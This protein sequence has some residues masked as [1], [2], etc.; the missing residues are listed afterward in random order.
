[1]AHNTFRKATA[2]NQDLSGWDV[3]KVTRMSNMFA[4]AYSFNQDISGWNVTLA[5]DMMEMFKSATSFGQDLC[6]WGALLQLDSSIV[7]VDDMFL[8][9]NCTYNEPSLDLGDGSWNQMCQSCGQA[10]G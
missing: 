5:E 4:H 8:Y 2:F 10:S 6:D 3:G 7:S 9:S 1:M